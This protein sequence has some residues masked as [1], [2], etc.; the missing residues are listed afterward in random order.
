MRQGGCRVHSCWAR[1]VFFS[2]FPFL[3]SAAQRDIEYGRLTAVVMVVSPRVWLSL[4][5]VSTM[6]FK[7]INHA[8][9]ACLDTTH[10]H[11]H[12]YTG[13][14][15]FLRCHASSHPQ[16]FSSMSPPTHDQAKLTSGIAT[17]TT[18]PTTPHTTRTLRS[19]RSTTPG[20]VEKRPR[21]GKGRGWSTQQAT[22]FRPFLHAV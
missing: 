1:F 13:T 7:K 3:C 10:T 17:T 9:L 15:S 18:V 22:R 6:N 14:H 19:G 8:S 16:P 21:Q 12:T 11:T 4:S 5:L 20:V 2:T